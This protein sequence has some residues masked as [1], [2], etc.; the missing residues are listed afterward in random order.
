M[1]SSVPGPTTGTSKRMSWRGF[2]TLTTT[3]PARRCRPR[4][5]DLVGP[6]HGLEG[7]RRPV[8]HGH[9]LAEV[10]PGQRARDRLAVLDVLLSSP[11]GCGAS[12]PR[13]RHLVGRKAVEAG[14]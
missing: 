1:A 12:W 4:A 7:H 11:D 14:A 3:R 5:D 10:H 13:R 9:R 6:L 8:L 2:A